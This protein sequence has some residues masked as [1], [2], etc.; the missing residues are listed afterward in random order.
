MVNEKVRAFAPASLSCFFKI[1]KH[2]NPRWVGSYGVGL[3]LDEGV[4]VSV[5][6]SKTTKIFF[7]KKPINFPTVRTVLARLGVEPLK[8]LLQS[9]L[10]LGYGFGLSGASALATA[11]AVNKL[12]GLGKSNKELAVIAHTAEVTN[13]TGLGNIVNQYYGGFFFKRKPSS[14]FVVERLSTRDTYVYCRYFS[15][16]LTKSVLANPFIQDKIDRAGSLALRQTKDLLKQTKEVRLHSFI[17]IGKVFVTG[18]NLLKNKKT[19][20]TIS[21]I[22]KN[23]GVATMLVLGNVVVSDTAFPGAIKLQLSDEGAHLL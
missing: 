6:K 15:R 16:L 14:Y 7:N 5:Q 11:Y 20:D 18:S 13:K 4:T 23:G 12:L 8:V 1:Y 9:D 19:R 17:Q 21:T 22:E 10:P 2:K 3:T